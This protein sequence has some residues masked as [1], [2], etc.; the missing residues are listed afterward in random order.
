MKFRIFSDIHLDHSP[1]VPKPMDYDSE[2][3]LIIAGDLYTGTRT[4]EIINWLND[5]AHD[6]K[7]VI[8]VMG[9][10]DYWTNRFGNDNWKHIPNI[11][12]KF[13]EPNVFLLEKE[14]VEL[15]GIK[16]GGATLWTDIDNYN[17]VVALEAHHYT[18]DFKFMP[19]MTPQLWM[20]EYAN[21]VKWI[22]ENPVD[23]LVTHY[24]PSS[25]FCHPRFKKDIGNCMF[26]SETIDQ[27]TNL[28]KLWVFGHTHDNYDEEVYGTKFIC[29]PRGYNY[30]NDSFK[31]GSLYEF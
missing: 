10:H 20:E 26:N 28:P 2:T 5:R 13:L 27:V 25:K 23:V 30:E 15:D 9:N 14:V 18:N 31:E 19:M 12:S 22:N 6:F 11:I 4:S 3:T 17:P 16:I 8:F 7:Y 1:W 21:T 24:V 29:N